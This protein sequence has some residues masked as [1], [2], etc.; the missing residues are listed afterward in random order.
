[1]ANVA[2]SLLGL[3]DHEFGHVFAQDGAVSEWLFDEMKAVLQDADT[4]EFYTSHH[5]D[6][7]LLVAV[8]VV[9]SE[10]H[11]LDLAQLVDRGLLSL[12]RII[13]MCSLYAQSNSHVMQWWLQRVFACAPHLANQVPM[14]HDIFYH[15]LLTIHHQVA[16]LKS[17]CIIDATRLQTQLC[18]I[19]KTIQALLTSHDMFL[20]IL[21]PPKATDLGHCFDGQTL[22]H[23]ILVCYETDLPLLNKLS[24]NDK[25]VPVARRH[26]LLSIG[27]WLDKTF[28]SVLKSEPA[29]AE[30]RT[31]WFFGV[32]NSLLHNADASEPASL[33][34]DLCRLL[35]FKT[36]CRRAF[37]EAAAVDDAQRD[38][39]ALLL[40]ELPERARSAKGDE[41]KPNGIVDSQDDK[42]AIVHSIGQQV[43]DIFPDLGAG[44]LQLVIAA[45]DYSSDKV[46]M[47][48]LEDALPPAV[49]SLDRTLTKND[50]RF[51]ALVA[52]SSLA[53]SP[54]T[55]DEATP[56][57]AKADPTQIWVGKKKQADKYKPES[58]RAN[59]EYMAKQLQ[60]AQTYDQ[61]PAWT[62]E[63]HVD[64]YNDDYNDELDEYEPFGVHDD[65]PTEYE[66][67][68]ARNKVVRA[69]EAED[70]FWESMRNPNHKPTASDDNDEDDDEDGDEG[71]TKPAARPL[72]QGLVP[73]KKTTE[74]TSANSRGGR[75]EQPQKKSTPSVLD[76]RSA[77][78]SQPPS[79]NATTSA[80][81]GP[82]TGDDPNKQLINRARK[83]QNK[84]SVANHRRKDKALKKQ[85]GGGGLF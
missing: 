7:L 23:A 48:L 54:P 80:K 39:L 13:A 24:R 41:P 3:T 34:S 53:A 44:F 76:K 21:T 11:G 68:I 59:P 60:L 4:D 83:E 25:L 65:E 31:E 35:Q 30:Q 46:I 49:A 29:Q 9:A 71:E 8:R 38:Y 17:P 74:A 63:T 45:C 27:L 56:T 72:R 5:G 70:A 1:M 55:V 18:D 36:T 52:T 81:K 69:R 79:A 66:E 16:S 43:K 19:A 20:S 28:L 64:E 42:A 58:V 84:S 6:N 50:P 10:D 32:L 14:L 67:I 78:A 47:A 85:G 2:T 61:E 26:V 77:A 15:A 57:P 22:L 82:A 73:A 40:S 51:A 33:L 75:Q 62:E 12:P 37:D